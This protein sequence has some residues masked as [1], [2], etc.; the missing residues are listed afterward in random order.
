PSLAVGTSWDNNVLVQPNDT[1]PPRD[2]ENTIGPRGTLGYNGA[3]GT[4]SASY[5]GT[6]FVYRTLN[7]LN[8][9]D[10]RLSFS[11]RRQTSPHT[12]FFVRDYAAIVPTT[13][14]VQLVA[15]P[16]VRAGSH[17]VDLRTGFEFATSEETTYIVSYD[18]QW[19]DF[20]Q[21]RL[22]FEVLHGG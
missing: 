19:V 17:V 1:H 16:F 10:Q 7:Q 20:E 13:E 14:L 22:L 2:V 5:D 3:R 21:S 8:S 4:L 12:A 9:F 15:V 11:A 18:F 6:F